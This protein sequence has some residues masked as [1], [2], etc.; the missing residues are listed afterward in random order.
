[1]SAAWKLV[2]TPLLAKYPGA[3]S[4]EFCWSSLWHCRSG[5]IAVG[6]TREIQCDRL[7]PRPRRSYPAKYQVLICRQLVR[8][9]LPRP[10]QLQASLP[11]SSR[12]VRNP[13]PQS[14][15]TAKLSRPNF[16]PLAAS[17][18]FEAGKKSRSGPETLAPST[19]DSTKRKS[20]SAETT[21]RSGRLL[22]VLEESY[23][24]PRRRLRR[25]EFLSFFSSFY[26]PS[27]TV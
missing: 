7:Q 6:S 1:M 27:S 9:Q 16:C 8:P 2:P 25:L 24:V 21:E 19:F 13:G 14:P 5:A 10:Q 11:S 3:C 12:P 18:W 23:P 22:S 20:T 26:R 4:P 17:A 15:P